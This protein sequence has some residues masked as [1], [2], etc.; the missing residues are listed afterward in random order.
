MLLV[1]FLKSLFLAMLDI[2]STPLFLLIKADCSFHIFKH[3]T[4]FD[5]EMSTELV[6]EECIEK[7]CVFIIGK[8]SVQFL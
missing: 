7:V 1:F 2:L 3:L 5:S 4:G 6:P 8:Q